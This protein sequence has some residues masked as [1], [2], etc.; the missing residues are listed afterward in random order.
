ME[1]PSKAKA[2]SWIDRRR[3]IADGSVAIV[4][5]ASSGIGRELTLLLAE[6]RCRVIAVARRQ[7]RL[8]ALVADASKLVPE[9][10]VYPVVGDV[11]DMSVCDEALAQARTLAQGRLDLLVNN[12][13]IGAIGRFMDADPDRMRQIMEVNF[14]APVQ[15][16]RA[17][18]GMLR[19]AAKDFSTRRSTPVICNI[20]SVLG[21]RAVPEKSEYCASKF[22]LHGWSDS[23]RAELTSEGI[24]VVLVSPSTTKSEFFDSLVGTEAG[25][26]SKSF[27][28]WPADRVARA[29]YSAIATCRSEVILSLGGK[30]LVYSDRLTPPLVNAIL[31]RTV[32]TPD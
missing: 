1:S 19:H 20:G 16:T 8:D 2:K 10:L 28:S 24:A 32:E 15:W 21:H 25:Q 31:A 17:A 12:A 14:H 4:T 26:K 5:G 23:L 18:M 27:G 9:R 13:G 22:A 29:T 6:K 7:E 30:A 3:W 11:T